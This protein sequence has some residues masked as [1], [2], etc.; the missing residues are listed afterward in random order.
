MHPPPPTAYVKSRP[1]PAQQAALD[2]FFALAPMGL[3]LGAE[4]KSLDAA[5]ARTAGT[6]AWSEALRS[7]IR[8]RLEAHQEGASL[9]GENDPALVALTLMCNAYGYP[10]AGYPHIVYDLD[11][12]ERASGMQQGTARGL[13]KAFCGIL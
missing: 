10:R 5:R 8:L 3:R 1:T 12:L 13:V 6:A 4:V 2:R 7:G 11:A 9:L